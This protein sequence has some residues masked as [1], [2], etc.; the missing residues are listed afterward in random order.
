M[1][2]G[3]YS[4]N[5]LALPVA[6]ICDYL[7]SLCRTIRYV[8]GKQL[9]RLP[10]SE[11]SGE[12]V[13]S[14]L[15]PQLLDE[16]SSLDMAILA[17]NVPYDN[18]YFYESR[19]HRLVLSFSGWNALTDLPLTNGLVFLLAGIIA[20][21]MGIGTTHNESTGCVNDFMW[22]KRIVDTGMRAAFICG[23]CLSSVS[24]DPLVQAVLTDIR[25][26]LDAVCH[27]SRSHLDIL[28]AD[29]LVSATI[30]HGFDVFMCH[31]SVDKPV[32][33]EINATMRAAGV[34][35]WLDEEQLKPGLPWQEGLEKQIGSIRRA[36]VFTGGSGT[37]PWQHAEL[38]AFLDEFASRGCPVIPVLLPDAPQVPELPMFLRQMMW[39]DLRSDY[40]KNLNRLIGAVTAAT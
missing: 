17:T 20:D 11:I 7:N 15:T 34:N 10:V 16:T 39:V 28:S 9:L 8:A 31:N 13:A 35:T 2:I 6:S 33:R 5:T 30:A 29:T 37:G 1:N 18:N 19:D 24:S 26:M 27:A 4:D 32:I 21:E 36:A 3:I 25:A 40:E 23:R 22:D 12:S 14:M 38:R